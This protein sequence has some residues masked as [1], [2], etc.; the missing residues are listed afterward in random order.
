VFILNTF[1]AGACTLV[2]CTRQTH[3]E[4]KGQG[5][6]HQGHLG[7]H[8]SIVLVDISWKSLFRNLKSKRLNV[9]SEI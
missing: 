7:D 3:L 9:K 2:N 5:C 1:F 6:Q 8:L 4:V